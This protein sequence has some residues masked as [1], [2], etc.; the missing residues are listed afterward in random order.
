MISTEQTL[1]IFREY[2]PP[3][4]VVRL[5]PVKQY[6][7]A[8][9]KLPFVRRQVELGIYDLTNIYTDFLSAVKVYTPY[10]MVDICYELF[11]NQFEGLTEEQAKALLCWSGAHEAQHLHAG[12]SNH[13]A[14]SEARR[15]ALCNAALARR[16]PKL[17]AMMNEV[18]YNSVVFQRVYARISQPAKGR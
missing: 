9:L 10:T 18:Q 1:A 11:Q 17:H 13:S 7:D 14:E 8:S 3:R 15:E 16:Y 12:H 4:T 5:V 2:L 6:V